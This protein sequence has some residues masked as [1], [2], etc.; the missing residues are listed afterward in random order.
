[1]T[2]KPTFVTPKGTAAYPYITKADFQYNAD[3][4]FKT[5]LRVAE[6]E[7]A[8]LITAI[9]EVVDDNFGSKAKAAKLPWKKDPETGMVEFAM[10]SKFRPKVVDSGGKPIPET[11]IPAIYG[12][13]TLKIAGVLFPYNAGGNIGVSLQMSGVQIVEL[14]EASGGNFDFGVEE[15]GFTHDEAA[16]DNEA[17]NGEAYNF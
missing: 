4:V 12:G 15:G 11:A 3:G 7:A 14:A 5:K 1:M 10:K 2:A 9:Q 6:A 8:D 17:S 16:N 13:S